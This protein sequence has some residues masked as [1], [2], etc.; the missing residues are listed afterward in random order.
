MS[1]YALTTEQALGD[2]IARVR[3]GQDVTASDL[4][5]RLMPWLAAHDAE[6]RA[7]V[8]AEEPE[9]RWQY[10]AQ[11]PD[12]AE[13]EIIPWS[14]GFMKRLVEYQGHRLFRRRPA[15]P[16]GPWVP[17]KQEGATDTCDAGG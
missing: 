8:V 5:N 17:V 9:V 1:D 15:V 11:N 3:H 10:G 16:A 6:V 12:D 14:R 13:G 2:E 4:A 7:G